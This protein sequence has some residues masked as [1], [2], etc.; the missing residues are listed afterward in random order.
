MRPL[1]QRSGVVYKVRRVSLTTPPDISDETHY[2]QGIY[3][4]NAI[5]ESAVILAEHFS[6]PV[7]DTI[8]SFLIRD[9]MRPT[10]NIRFTRA[11]VAGCV[12]MHCGALIRLACYRT[13]GRLFTWEL[14]LKKGHVLM[15]GGP[16]SIVR[17]PSYTGSLLLGTGVA[18]CHFSPGSWYAECIGW[19]T[20]ASR[21]FSAA[22]IAWSL[23]VP[24]LLMARVDTEDDVLRKEFGEE[25]DE[26]AKKTPYRLIPYLY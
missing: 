14:T 3:W 9:T 24:A 2:T 4:A 18:L 13:L 22:W 20:W 1:L 5:L 16:Y 25:W 6:S 15:T 7:S 8:L 23:A 17:H 19:D 10:H 26:Y 11:W 12:L 21:I